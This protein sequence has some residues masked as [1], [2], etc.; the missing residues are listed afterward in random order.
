MENSYSVELFNRVKDWLE[1]REYDFTIYEDKGIFKLEYSIDSS[2][3]K[4][5]LILII[6]EK[7][8]SSRSIIPIG[9]L[10]IR[11]P[12]I[13]ECITR[14]NY[15]LIDGSFE[16]DFSDGE[17]AFKMH[18]QVPNEL[19]TDDDLYRMVAIHSLMWSKYSD[20]FLKVAFAD[21]EPQDAIA[22]IEK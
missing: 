5:T 20:V 19:P 6:R 22:Q 4:F 8:I 15:S 16:M 3:R 17:V 18:I 7:G 13:A 11:R 14:L 1:K 9:A 10:E 2:I 21:V 12:A